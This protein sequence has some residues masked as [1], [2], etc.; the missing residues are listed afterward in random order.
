[1]V[2]L[3]FFPHGLCVLLSF[4]SHSVCRASKESWSH[5]KACLEVFSFIFLYFWIPVPSEPHL[6][7]LLGLKNI[8][9]NRKKKK[10]HTKSELSTLSCWVICSKPKMPLH[11]TPETPFWGLSLLNLS[12]FCAVAVPTIC[13]EVPAT[14]SY[15]CFKTSHS[16]ATLSW[17]QSS[18]FNYRLRLPFSSCEVVAI[19][20]I[21]RVGGLL[22]SHIPHR[23]PL[24]DCLPSLP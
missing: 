5:W 13:L 7:S 8:Y 21:W 22:S 23:G 20:F 14:L 16:L 2:F 17:S 19:L 24:S 9:P 10:N 12:P 1:M 6:F 18:H 4:C 11:P 15:L 3:H